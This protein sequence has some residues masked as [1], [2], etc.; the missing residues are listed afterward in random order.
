MSSYFAPGFR[1]GPGDRKPRKTQSPSWRKLHVT[2]WAT[3]GHLAAT[4]QCDTFPRA[5]RGVNTDRVP[6]A[7]LRVREGAGQCGWQKEDISG[8]RCGLSKGG[9]KGAGAR[10]TVSGAGCRACGLCPVCSGA[11]PG[12]TMP[13]R[14]HLVITIIFNI[15]III[16]LTPKMAFSNI[17]NSFLADGSKRCCYHKKLMYYDNFLTIE[18]K[19]II[20]KGLVYNIYIHI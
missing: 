16:L 17:Y 18:I 4:T 6:T 9:G 20:L 8:G 13:L 7:K 15:I 10:H 14:R 3:V 12:G 5:G 19:H 1:L 2:V 11:I